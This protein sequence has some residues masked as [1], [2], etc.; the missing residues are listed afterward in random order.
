LHPIFEVAFAISDET[1]EA[2]ESGASASNAMPL[3]RA[4]GE[5][6]KT[7]RSFLIEKAIHFVFCRSKWFVG[8]T[9]KQLKFAGKVLPTL[10]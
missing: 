8:R 9:N 3:Q 4:H 7:R 6:E 10:P 5:A 2:G 1:P